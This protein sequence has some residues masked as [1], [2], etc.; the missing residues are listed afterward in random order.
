MAELAGYLRR[1]DVAPGR[2]PLGDA[3]GGGVL[4]AKKRLGRLFTKN[5]ICAILF[6][7]K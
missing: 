4:E 7:L 1:V 5:R 2:P 3:A 6:H